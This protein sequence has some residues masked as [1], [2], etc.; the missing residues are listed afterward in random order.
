M[1]EYS[2]ATSVQTKFK[3]EDY[4]DQSFLSFPKNS[5]LS[6]HQLASVLFGSLAPSSLVMPKIALTNSSTYEHV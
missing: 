3:S 4:K 6:H 1:C 2:Q 5:W